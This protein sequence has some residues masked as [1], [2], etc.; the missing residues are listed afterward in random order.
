[1]LAVSEA[2]HQTTPIKR[3]LENHI[4]DVQ[5]HLKN[6]NTED[7]NSILEVLLLARERKSNIYIFGNGGSAATAMHMATDFSKTIEASGMP[8]KAI[9]LNSNVS[10]ITAIANDHGYENVF[11]EQMEY[12]LQPDDVVIG[13]SASGNSPNC[14]KAFQLAKERKAINIGLLGFSGGKMKELSD[15][16]LHVPIESYFIVEDVHMVVSH[17][18]TA[19]LRS[20]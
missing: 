18:L 4:I 16:L 7:V 20:S 10:A 9:C 3:A 2:I 8:V 5:K 15:Y 13:I 12:L 17:A 14:V 6:I 19:G 11:S 1:M